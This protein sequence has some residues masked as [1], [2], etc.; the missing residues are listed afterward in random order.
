MPVARIREDRTWRDYLRLALAQRGS[1]ESIAWGVAIGMFVAFTPTLGI[2][3]ILALIVTSL[4]HVNR[5]ASIPPLFIT[6]VLTAGPI[7]GFQCW[8]GAQFLPDA[9][10]AEMLARWEKVQQLVANTGILSLHENWRDLARISGDLW[11][12]MW[13]GGILVG[14]ILAVPYYFV[15]LAVVRRHREHRARRLRVRSQTRSTGT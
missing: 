7:Y 15:T 8:L 14:G 6:N 12:A 5:L 9:R 11:L 2:Q 13:I 10:S 4:V 3:I 1:P